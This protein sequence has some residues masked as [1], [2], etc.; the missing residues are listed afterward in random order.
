M[1]ALSETFGVET[2]RLARPARG[3]LVDYAS[4]LGASGIGRTAQQVVLADS[5]YIGDRAVLHPDDPRWPE[6]RV[7]TG[8]VMGAVQSGKTASMIGVLARALDNGANIAIVLAGTQTGLW[9]QTLSR[10]SAQLDSGTDP[11]RRRIFLPIPTETLGPTRPGPAQAYNLSE[12]AAERA[13][14]LGRPLVVVAMKQVDHLLHLGQTLHRVAF[15]AAAAQGVKVNMVVIDDEADD[16]SIA[17]DGLPWSSPDLE[18]FK[19]V[20]RRIVDLWE[21]RNAPGETAAEHVY[22]T[23][24]AYTA[25]PQANFLQ[26]LTNPLAPRNFVAALRTPGEEGALEPRSLT[27]RVPEGLR[28]WYT[29]ADIFYGDV[30]ASLTVTE[31]QCNRSNP[32]PSGAAG[33]HPN[34][35]DATERAVQDAVRGYLVGSAVRLLRSGL[36]GPS[37]ARAR[38]FA[39]RDDVDASVAP[40]TSMLVHPS[41]SLETHFETATALRSWWAGDGTTPWAGV[42]A[43]VTANE[44]AWTRWVQSYKSSATAVARRYEPH[45]SGSSTREVGTWDALRRLILDEVAPATEIS[46]VNSDP[47]ADDR[48]KFSPWQDRDGWHAPKNHSTIFVAGNVMSR[49]L[50]LEGLQMT[51][52]TRGSAG[53]LADTQ[54]Q[55]QR[56]FGYRGSYVD[57]CR[58]ILSPQQLALFTQYADADHALRSQVLAAMLTNA[59]SLP[60]F[61]VLQGESFQATGKVTGLVSRPLSPG[62]RPLVRYLNPPGKDDSNLSVVSTLFLEADRAGVLRRGASGLV[63][64]VSL[65]LL[66]TADL[67]DRL[68]YAEHG[69]VPL[70]RQ[71]WAALERQ[72]QLA[73]TDPEYPLYR[74]PEAGAEA[75]DLGHHSPYVIAAYLRFWAAC[76][77]RQ[78]RGVIAGGRSP[79][80]WNLLDLETKRALQPRFR[81]ALRFGMGAPLNQGPMLSLATALHREI[82]PMAREVTEGKLAAG[83]G[84]RKAVGSGFTGDDLL[85]YRI[86]GGD[87]D[88]HE[89]GTRREGSPGLVV[90]QLI[91]SHDGR[92]AVAVGLSIPSGGPDHMEAVSTSRTKGVR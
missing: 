72:A 1:V 87:P 26:D 90:F 51:V 49:G 53:P 3:W 68:S 18:V 59:S 79:Q 62:P 75:I 57:L 11:L 81:V 89:D 12:R 40:V 78:V 85:D 58:V 29:G 16:S 2:L 63:A 55:M 66:S 23:Y 30:A 71:R 33:S 42:A 34:G 14:R 8:V 15:R 73:S 67:L 31:H 13:F 32:V 20:P 41:S 70:E 52:F 56:W 7:R 48:P 9:L 10:I 19:Q 44:A 69:A 64:D 65:D 74:A 4:A 25:T 82:R 77:D 28:G 60:D 27:Y 92:G 17:D 83:W 38:L 45:L 36:M 6:S 39:D 84:S 21:N 80:R 88:L 35:A 76:L 46:V 47:A 50:T 86:L 24:I 37:S 5:E 54:M 91:D 43:D 22:A 61:A